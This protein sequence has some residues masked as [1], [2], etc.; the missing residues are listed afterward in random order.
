MSR[1]LLS[2][3]NFLNFNWFLKLFYSI[4][5]YRSSSKLLLSRSTSDALLN[6]TISLPRIRNFECN[7]CGTSNP[8]QSNHFIGGSYADIFSEYATCVLSLDKIHLKYPHSH[9]DIIKHVGFVSLSDWIFIKEFCRITHI[10]F[11]HMQKE[12]LN[13]KKGKILWDYLLL[14]IN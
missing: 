10:I 3:T 13:L 12:Y 6:T 9:D 7:Y 11:Q 2:S 8:K 5:C 1:Y 4:D 14:F